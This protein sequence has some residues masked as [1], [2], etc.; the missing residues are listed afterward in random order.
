MSAANG[1]PDRLADLTRAAISGDPGSVADAITAALTTGDA[2][3]ELTAAYPGW[4]FDISP[5]GMWSAWQCS[6]DGRHRRIIMAPTAGQLAER[7]DA[8]RGGGDPG[9][10]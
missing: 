10:A 5:L 2:C 9:C 6:E 1:S 8:I 3:E 7:L 4:E